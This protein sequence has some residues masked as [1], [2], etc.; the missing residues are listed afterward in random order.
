M[1]SVSV[2]VHTTVS[3]LLVQQT[4]VELMS[5]LQTRWD[6]KPHNYVSDILHSYMRFPHDNNHGLLSD[7]SLAVSFNGSSA[8]GLWYEY[9]AA[10]G[11][12]PP[13]SS[14]IRQPWK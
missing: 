2:F 9:F 6:A 13:L 12:G 3:A 4:W 11:V 7:Y 8:T 14:E 10:F 5:S 1:G